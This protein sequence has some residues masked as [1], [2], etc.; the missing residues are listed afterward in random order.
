MF[1]AVWLLGFLR[2]FVTSPSLALTSARVMA[3]VPMF[4]VLSLFRLTERQ[5][6][7]I[8]R[9]I[10]VAAVM[11]SAILVLRL[12]FG[13][14]LFYQISFRN[15]SDVNDGGR[16]LS[17][18]AALI[19]AGGVVV[20]FARAYRAKHSG[21]PSRSH[22]RNGAV[23]AGLLLLSFQASATLA[24]IAGLA[25]VLALAPGHSVSLRR[26]TVISAVGAFA[27]LWFVA[28]EA[29][30]IDSYISMLPPEIADQL[31][32]RTG[33]LDTR[34]EVWSGFLHSFD[35]RNTFDQMFGLA[36]G[37]R[38]QIVVQLWGGTYWEHALHSGY[39]GLLS[40][41]GYLGLSAFILMLVTISAV[42]LRRL[43]KPGFDFAHLAPALAAML[44]VFGIGYDIR[45]EHGVFILLAVASAT[46][47]KAT[48]EPDAEI[49]KAPMTSGPRAY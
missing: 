33:N 28:P 42:G 18:Q 35:A 47:P 12:M 45:N 43:T 15:L 13:A 34:I 14:N 36:A 21:T 11:V 9:A 23:F 16:G 2:G 49:G 27:A 44:L 6:D 8:F 41:V 38:E 25:I 4:T 3:I 48:A 32:R 24:G 26:T 10:N 37:Q 22:R 1:I 30:S 29:L 7:G 46:R 19:L 39:F 20:S 31:G 17:A 5:R 40:S